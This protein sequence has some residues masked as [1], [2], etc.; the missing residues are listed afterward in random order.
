MMSSPAP[1]SPFFLNHYP[2]LTYSNNTWTPSSASPPI[3]FLSPFFF[4]FFLSLPLPL[5]LNTKLPSLIKKFSTLASSTHDPPL[6]SGRPSSYH[7]LSFSNLSCLL[8]IK[9]STECSLH[10]SIHPQLPRVGR[11]PL[12]F[13]HY[14]TP[15]NQLVIVDNR[16]SSAIN[17]E[18]CVHAS[19]A[20]R[21]LPSSSINSLSLASP[22]TSHALSNAGFVWLVGF[23]KG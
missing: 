20:I 11:F 22:H 13:Y 3:T 10:Q 12:K 8:P 21:P 1:S 15:Y 2:W 4:H 7:Y 23:M 19:L 5:L 9:L 17:K 6:T 16:E 18:K 14:F